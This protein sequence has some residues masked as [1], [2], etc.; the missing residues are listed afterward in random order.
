MQLRYKKMCYLCIFPL[1]I[2]RK[3][4]ML[5]IRCTNTCASASVCTKQM[6]LWVCPLCVWHLLWDVC[7]R[8][9]REHD[10]QRRPGPRI[11]GWIWP[12]R[13]SPTVDEVLGKLQ[14]NKE[15]FQLLARN[16]ALCNLTNIMDSG[17]VVDDDAIKA[18][19]QVQS[20]SAVDNMSLCFTW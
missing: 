12:R 20:G 5:S 4:R 1:P 7:Y 17:L 11:M 8:Q 3:T 9:V 14:K 19:F 15:D 13:C 2:T 10:E 6:S 16:K 18:Q